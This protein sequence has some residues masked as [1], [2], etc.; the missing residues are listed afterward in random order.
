MRDVYDSPITIRVKYTKSIESKTESEWLYNT[1]PECQQ[2]KSNFW[3]QRELD[4]E[5]C[6]ENMDICDKNCRCKSN[7]PEYTEKKTYVTPKHAQ[8]SSSEPTAQLLSSTFQKP[9]ISSSLH[10]CNSK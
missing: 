8:P 10:Q 3:G 1:S 6:Y 9:T 5:W 4:F 7:C 2:A